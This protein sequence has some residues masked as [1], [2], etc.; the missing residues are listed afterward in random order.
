MLI[1]PNPAYTIKYPKAIDFINQ[2]LSVFWFPEEI[3]VEKDVQDIL[4]NLT[5]A[6]RHGVITTLKLFTKYETIIGKEYWT[7]VMGM[8]H[9]PADI[10][11]MA[12]LFS[13][14]ELNVHAPSSK[15][16]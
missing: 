1:T 16:A 11:R 7:Q 6:E 2:Q 12:N 3:K 9:H 5:P 4:T 10:Q 15:A 13:F 8:F 14:F